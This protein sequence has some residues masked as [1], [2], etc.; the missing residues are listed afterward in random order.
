M[1][2]TIRTSLLALF[3]AYSVHNYNFKYQKKSETPIKCDIYAAGKGTDE[4]GKPFEVYVK[5]F[6]IVKTNS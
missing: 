3:L 6:V 1:R 5:L 4:N 2:F